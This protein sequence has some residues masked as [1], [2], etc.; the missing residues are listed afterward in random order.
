MKIFTG[1]FAR[2]EN[3]RIFTPVI[4]TKANKMT[5]TKTY[6]GE[7]Q[8]KHNGQ[9]FTIQNMETCSVDAWNG[10]K[11]EKWHIY[12]DTTNDFV[13]AVGTKKYALTIISRQG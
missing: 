13:A 3:S 9:I 4:T 1:K 11:D 2:K 7:Y 10:G 5:A 12:N 8:V 6:K